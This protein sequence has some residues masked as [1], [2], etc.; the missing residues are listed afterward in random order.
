M[1]KILYLIEINSKFIVDVN[2]K[3]KS[4]ILLEENIGENIHDLGTKFLALKSRRH[5]LK[6]YNEPVLN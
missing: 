2:I 3:H 1:I 6:R 4:I 5:P